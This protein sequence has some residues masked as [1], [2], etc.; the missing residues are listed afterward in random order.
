[1]RLSSADEPHPSK[2]DSG[3]DAGSNDARVTPEQIPDSSRILARQI[4]IFVRAILL[5]TGARGRVWWRA[6]RAT[7]QTAGASLEERWPG[8]K[9]GLQSSIKSV[10]WP[11]LGL[12]SSFTGCRPG[13][14]PEEWRSPRSTRFRAKYLV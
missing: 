1:M 14:V 9:A 6:Q 12:K 5:N 8:L 4:V 3:G 7:I 2:A 10:R 13:V 11:D